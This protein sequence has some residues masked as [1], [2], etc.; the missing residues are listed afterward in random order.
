MIISGTAMA[1]SP[2]MSTDLLLVGLIYNHFASHALTHV[3]SCGMGLRAAPI[4]MTFRPFPRE[5]RDGRSIASSH[6]RVPIP[7]TF[8]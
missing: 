4:L 8:Q 2:G 1:G 7:P 6:L 3:G 5:Q